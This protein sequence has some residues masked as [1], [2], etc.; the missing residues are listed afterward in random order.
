MTMSL[1]EL[2]IF[3][4]AITFFILVIYLVPTIIQ[5]RRTARS[6]EELAELAKKQVRGLEEVINRLSHWKSPLAAL[7]G[8]IAFIRSGLIKI[9]KGG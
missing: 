3:F 8:L 1:M 5:L 2:S 4:I 9:K 7:A 6:V